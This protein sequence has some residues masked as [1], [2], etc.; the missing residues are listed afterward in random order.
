M[1]G[2]KRSIPAIL[3]NLSLSAIS[4]FFFGLKAES[5]VNEPLNIY[6]AGSFTGIMPFLAEGIF[7]AASVLAKQ[8][9]ATGGVAGRQL[10]VIKQDD[11][12]DVEKALKFAEK[13]LSDSNHFVTIGQPFSSVAIPVAKLYKTKNKL[14]MTPYA[15]SAELSKIQGTT[16]Q[17]CFNDVFQGEILAKVARERLK[18]QRILVLRNMSDPYSDGLAESFISSI[19]ASQTPTKNEFEVSEFRYITSGFDTD[20]FKK[21]FDTFKPDVVFLPEL[22]VRAAEILRDVERRN[23]KL[24]KVLGADGW[25]S[26]NGTLDIF[27]DSDGKSHPQKYFY[28]YH[29]HPSVKTKRSEEVKNLLEKST[30]KNAYGPGVIA[31]DALSWL[32]EGARKTASADAEVLAR[33]LR[34]NTFDGVTGPVSFRNNGNTERSLV[35]IE[36][37][38]SGLKF[39]SLVAPK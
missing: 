15:T 9:N 18:S 26:E 29:W 12:A 38:P 10:V 34:S 22:K 3:L 35:L 20:A 32:I 30:Q 1:S 37:S 6:V 25:G 8:V 36:L 31:F 14:F 16:F 19:K 17:L 33:Y 28:T 27:F 5:K 39:D 4:A 7:D 13:A 2:R 11:Q 21:V 23:I 24:P